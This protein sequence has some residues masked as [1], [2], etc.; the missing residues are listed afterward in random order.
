LRKSG[1]G[2]KRRGE[3]EKRSAERQRKK[4]GDGRRK[5]A[6]GRS[7]RSAGARRKRQQKLDWSRSVNDL[8]VRVTLVYVANSS[9][10][11][12]PSSDSLHNEPG[13]TETIAVVSKNSRRNSSWHGSVKLST[14][15]RD[16]TVRTGENRHL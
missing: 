3:P 6:S 13:I 4:S 7:R 14:S 11:T 9:A 12:R 1:G 2:K 15:V 8:G 10:S 5:S 16:K